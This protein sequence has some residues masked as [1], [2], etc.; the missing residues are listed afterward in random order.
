MRWTEEEVAKLRELL[1]VDRTYQSIGAELGR[2]K[3]AVQM[4]AASLGFGPKPFK[5][6]KSPVWPFIVKLCSDG[7]PRTVHELIEQTGVS[8]VCIDRLMKDREKE[9]LAHVARWQRNRRGPPTPF[10]LAVPGKSVPKPKAVSPSER[11]CARMRRMKEEDPLRYKAIVD[12]ATI[13]RKMKRGVLAHQHPI[14]QALF[15]MGM[16]V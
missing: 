13:R 15:G 8:R 11:Q 16:R 14:V 3:D 2:S 9:G 4:K 6:N 7:R 10:W 12:R 1:T 5:G